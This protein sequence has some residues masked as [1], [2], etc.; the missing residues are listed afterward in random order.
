MNLKRIRNIIIGASVIVL[1]P[2]VAF[3]ILDYDLFLMEGQHLE[4]NL[5]IISTIAAMWSVGFKLTFDILM[6]KADRREKIASFIIFYLILPIIFILSLQKIVPIP[7]STSMV[8]RAGFSFVYGTSVMVGYDFIKPAKLE[9]KECEKRKMWLYTV[10]KVE[11]K[12]AFVETLLIISGILVAFN[13]TPLKINIFVI[14]AIGSI[15]FIIWISILQKKYKNKK[16]TI[17]PLIVNWVLASYVGL[18]FSSLIYLVA[19]EAGLSSGGNIWTLLGGWTI[20]YFM[21][22]V[23]LMVVL[24][25]SDEGRIE[26]IAT[27]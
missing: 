20:A 26:P 16:F 24:G 13:S 4:P 8:A 17:G 12:R 3:F 9:K 18:F 23:L 14:L 15:A 2:N 7:I 10:L 6:S 21:L 19:M 11:E 25:L 1:F 22:W 5:Y 27:K